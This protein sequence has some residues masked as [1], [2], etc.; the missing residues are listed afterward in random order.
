VYDPSAV[1]LRAAT[2]VGNGGSNRGQGARRKV[3]AHP[4]RTPL[5]A[6][7]GRHRVR[8]VEGNTAVTTPESACVVTEDA[9]ET[10]EEIADTPVTV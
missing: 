4:C 3:F 5:D 9:P 8:E 1:G 2:R 7:D 10:V 6:A